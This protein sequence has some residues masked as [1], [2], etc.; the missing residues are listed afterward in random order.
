MC[1]II[2]EI[3]NSENLISQVGKVLCNRYHK[4]YRKKI[5][6]NNIRRM[7]ISYKESKIEDQIVSIRLNIT[8]KAVAASLFMGQFY[9]CKEVN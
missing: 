5:Y 2:C 6:F 7:E 3:T 1:G 8:V 4:I 9:G